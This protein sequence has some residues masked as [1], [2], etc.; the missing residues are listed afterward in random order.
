MRKDMHS[1]AI[2]IP[3][4]KS[5][6]LRETLES[7]ANQ[8]DRRFTLY[9]GD[10]CSPYNI[11]SIVDEY[12]NRIEIVYKRFSENLGGR[13]LVAQWERCIDMT[14]GEP[15]I[16]LFSDDDI[17][18]KRCVEAFNCLETDVKDNS[19][20]HYNIKMIDDIGGCQIKELPLFPVRMSVGEYLEAKLR[21]EVVSF[22][23]EFIF[24]RK[25]YNKVG[26]FQ[27][28]DLAWGS[29]FMTWLKMAAVAKNGIVTIGAKENFVKWRKSNENISPNNTHN[30]ILRKIRSLIDN[31]AFL[32]SH[33]EKFPESYYPLRKGFRWL[34]FPLGEIYRKRK[35]LTRKEKK[36]LLKLYYAKVGYPFQ[37]LFVYLR[38]I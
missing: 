17:M 27:S 7:V 15:Y 32:K 33:M 4:Y 12:K 2:V 10:D 34:R 19:L 11:K 37:S 3:A 26:G 9:V 21:G 14:K 25:L 20:C 31:A 36:D 29:D 8:T 24:P 5:T 30:M 16:W 18:D 13:D 23:V 1:L 38:V 6:Y 28:F 35:H 22:V